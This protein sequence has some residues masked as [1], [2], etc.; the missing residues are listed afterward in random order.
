MEPMLE[1]GPMVSISTPPCLEV[2]EPVDRPSAP[3]TVPA[4]PRFDAS[5]PAE[6]P[7]EAPR[8]HGRA[9]FARVLFVL[10]FGGAASLLGYAFKAPLTDAAERV[11][12]LAVPA[13]A[14]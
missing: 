9:M 7:V 4:P 10:L 6:A 5:E 13:V 12:A 2:P 8:G 3:T 14:R 1:S 11:R